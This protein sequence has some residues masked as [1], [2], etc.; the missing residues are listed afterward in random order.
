ME[1]RLV[2][3]SI[4]VSALMKEN[5]TLR[6]T[7]LELSQS[8][9][10]KDEAYVGLAVENEELIGALERARQHSGAAVGVSTQALNKVSPKED[11]FVEVLVGTTDDTQD[12]H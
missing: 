9:E 2:D 3:N 11:I 8:S 10:K 12:F 1:V 7:V 5:K 6:R 4:F